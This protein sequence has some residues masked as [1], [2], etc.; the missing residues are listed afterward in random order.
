MGR[1]DKSLLANVPAIDRS[2]PKNLQTAT[3][4]FG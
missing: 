3:F 2:M 4:A 1:T